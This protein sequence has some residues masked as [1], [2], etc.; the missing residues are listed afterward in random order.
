MCAVSS[1]ISPLA[2]VSIRTC[3]QVLGFLDEDGKLAES[4][5]KSEC[6]EPVT[7]RPGQ[8]LEGLPGQ[9]AESLLAPIDP[10]DARSSSRLP[11]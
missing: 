1:G 6:E 11:E 2:L 8:A 5:D 7:P 9:T 10:A 3:S 4:S